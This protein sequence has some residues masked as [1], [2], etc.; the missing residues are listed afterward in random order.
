MRML[1]TSSGLTA[2]FING[3]QF[4]VCDANHHCHVVNDRQTAYRVV[5]DAETRGISLDDALA[6]R[7]R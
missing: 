5:A 1:R 6:E 7:E 3:G 2:D 4:R